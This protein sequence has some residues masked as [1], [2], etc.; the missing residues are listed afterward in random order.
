MA[1]AQDLRGAVRRGANGGVFGIYGQF[2]TVVLGA[3]RWYV[4]DEANTVVLFTTG[5]TYVLSP[6]DPEAFLTA[7]AAEPAPTG[8]H[9]GSC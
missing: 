7:I 6:D 2:E 9:P 8:V 1:T 4:T 3:C 5:E